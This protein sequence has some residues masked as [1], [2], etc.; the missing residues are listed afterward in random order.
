MK[1][2]FILTSS[3]FFGSKVQF[4]SSQLGN[5]ATC[6]ANIEC[7]SNL[8]ISSVIP[9][10][11]S[12]GQEGSACDFSSQCAIE[13]SGGYC[14]QNQC[15]ANPPVVESDLCAGVDCGPGAGNKCI[16]VSAYAA[17]CQCENTF[18]QSIDSK[19]RPTCACQDDW[20]FDASVN[21]CFAPPTFAPS[22]TPTVTPS[23]SPTSFPSAQP[24]SAPVEAT[25]TCTER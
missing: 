19:G 18:V 13:P 22:K 7:V 11:C 14:V 24:S 2:N 3:L 8:C 12:N 21:R 23:K 17:A 4:G 25:A 16:I 5:G 1:L 20:N 10:V 6:T 15:T 9:N